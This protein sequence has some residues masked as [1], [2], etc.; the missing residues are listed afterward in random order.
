MPNS[1]F[2][3]D[4]GIVT[5]ALVN[6]DNAAVRRLANVVQPELDWVHLEHDADQGA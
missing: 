4:A 5:Q 6:P 3:L 1:L 2:C